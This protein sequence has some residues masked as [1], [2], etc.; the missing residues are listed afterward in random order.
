MSNTRSFTPGNPSSLERISCSSVGQSI[1]LMLKDVLTM[2]IR[3]ASLFFRLVQ[4]FGNIPVKV[5]RQVVQ[6]VR[7][8]DVEPRDMLDPDTDRL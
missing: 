7:Q 4:I 3:S 2:V 6:G 5:S 1:F 8:P